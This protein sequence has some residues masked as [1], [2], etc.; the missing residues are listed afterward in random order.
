MDKF[1]TN[2]HPHIHIHQLH[3]IN[4]H[5]KKHAILYKVIPYTLYL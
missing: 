4:K 5:I 2:H 3:A 1:I